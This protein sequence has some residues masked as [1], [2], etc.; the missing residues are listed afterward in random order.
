MP[1]EN[2][3]EDGLVEI[4]L[5]GV[6]IDLSTEYACLEVVFRVDININFTVSGVVNSSPDVGN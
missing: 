4:D 1:R 2:G 3:A 6:N 5:S